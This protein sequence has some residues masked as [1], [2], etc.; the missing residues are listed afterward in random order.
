[1]AECEL[2]SLEGIMNLFGSLAVDTTTVAFV[3]DE[4]KTC[5]LNQDVISS[6]TTKICMSPDF[7]VCRVKHH[8]VICC[9]LQKIY[10]HRG[11]QKQA[12]FIF[13]F[14]ITLPNVDRFYFFTFPFRD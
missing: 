5:H 14:T 1:M 8:K 12:T 3:L 11:P 9:H 13:I 4:S 6:I 7:T 10:I 2:S